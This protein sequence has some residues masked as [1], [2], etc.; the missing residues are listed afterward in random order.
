MDILVTGGAGFIGSC[1]VAALLESGNDITVIDNFND[2]YNPRYKRQNIQPFLQNRHFTL[3]EGDITNKF[4]LRTVFE[5]NTFVKVIH[6]AASVGVRNSLIHPR[7]Y[8]RNNVVGTQ[9]MLDML[10]MYGVKQFLF[11]SSSSV[12][13]NNSR[14]P[15][16]EDQVAESLLNPYAQTKKD[17]EALC[18]R[19]HDQTGVPI[20]IFR[21]FTVFGPGGRPDMSPYIFTKAVLE[22]KPVRIYGDGMAQ[23]DFTYIDD[24]VSGIVL[25]M[26]K[27]LGCETF[28]LGNSAP[29]SVLD[30]VKM[31]GDICNKK[32]NLVFLPRNNFEMLRTYADISKAKKL[33]GF[34]PNTTL[35]KGLPA[36][37]RWF[38]QNNR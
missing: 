4:L 33:L 19:Y 37:I 28:N 27:P 20:T 11:A 13:G 16:K 38:R 31:I 15:F 6:L 10:D 12:Y 34:Q 2:Y 7:K 8:I 32:P 36:F 5:H 29:V 3:V 1:V 30:F 23:R 9:N 26:D 24:I 14:V 17:A 22:G 21:F 25:A 35:D 18:R